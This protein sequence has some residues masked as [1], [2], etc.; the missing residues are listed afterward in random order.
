MASR[1][2]DAYVRK[3]F[4][5]DG[6]TDLVSL[7]RALSQRGLTDALVR[8]GDRIGVFTTTNLRDALLRETPPHL[9]PVRE[10][11]TFDPYSVSIDDELYDAMLLMLRHRIHR[12]VVREGPSI[13]GLLSQIDLMAFVA[14]HSHLIALEIAE[15]TDQDELKTAARQIDD[16]IADLQDDGV[17]VEVIGELVGELN[18]RLFQR[19]WELLAPQS[20]RENSCLLVMGSEGRGEQ[21]IKTDQDNALILR[22]GFA[23]EGLEAITAAFTAGLIDFGYP[24]CPG[25]I[26]VS[27]PLWCQPLS[28]FKDTLKRWLFAAEADGPMNLAIF[29]DAAVAAG[30]PHLLEQARAHLDFLLQDDAA[31]FGR[32]ARAVEQFG[33]GGAWWSRLPGLRG[34]AAAEIDLKKLG[35]FPIVHGVRALSLQYRVMPL[36]TV[37]RIRALVDEGRLDAPLGRDLADALHCLMGLKLSNNLRQMAAGQAPG[38]TLPLSALGT[39]DRQ[40]LRDSLAIVRGFKQWLGRHY[41]FDLL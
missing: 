27:R 23:L 39:L 29:L 19:L 34:R 17:R 40:A 8:D 15:A 22:D 4:F 16:L 9:L 10:A 2:R 38:N 26:M 37:A 25:G 18:R 33:D 7:C 31:Y 3:P 12:V 11:A 41:R 36:A 35:I 5:V 32:F 28:G 13:V 21:L 6:G 30:D 14:S 20:L 24:P 1:V